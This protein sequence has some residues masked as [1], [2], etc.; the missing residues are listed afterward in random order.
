MKSTSPI[1]NAPVPKS[2]S[3]TRPTFGLGLRP[4][5]ESSEIGRALLPPG[6]SPG[7]QMHPGA[8][9]SHHPP[10]SV[11]PASATV[12]KGA[13]LVSLSLCEG[14]KR[15]G[16]AKMQ[17]AA[18]TNR[19]FTGC[20]SKAE[21]AD[22]EI[23][24][25]LGRSLRLI[26]ASHLAQTVHSQGSFLKLANVLIHAAEQ[27]Y[28][29]RDVDALQELST[30]LM[31]LPIDGAWQIGLYYR[32][33]AMKRKGLIDEAH[34]LLETVADNAPLSYRARALQSLGTNHHTKC[35]LDDAFM[36]QLEALRVA[37]DQNANGLRTTLLAHLEI[38]HLK[39]EMGDH[40]GALDVLEATSPLVQ[41]VSRQ[42]PLYFYFYHNELAVEF[43][44]LNRIAEAE[45]ACAIALASPFAR[46]YPEWRDTRDE[47]AAKR[48][49]A[50]PSV[51]AIHTA[52]EADLATQAESQ[53]KPEPTT[54][55]VFRCSTSKRD[56]LQF[57]NRTPRRATATI[58]L[59]AIS[60]LDQVLICVGS[61]APL[62]APES[63]SNQP[64]KLNRKVGRLFWRQRP[65][66][67][68]RARSCVRIGSSKARLCAGER[69]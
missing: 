23:V 20:S 46:A 47:V 45:A 66:L 60:I 9:Q 63:V 42:N 55:P 14:E 5:P 26:V 64:K 54:V 25:D 69:A 11:R 10:A 36:L 30:V 62:H 51:V 18:N 38:S 24:V 2:S 15:S 21:F 40:Q 56:S 12:A 34:P 43:G 17:A 13:G 33:L 27:A 52:P 19:F 67:P 49:S 44:E 48:K 61:R 65:T 6:F 4:A 16:R 8:P 7:S 31:N 37:S 35:R 57:V 29:I 53:S 59:N 1:K 58:D 3:E 22:S 39:S 32:A 68:I 41:I 50:S 28:M